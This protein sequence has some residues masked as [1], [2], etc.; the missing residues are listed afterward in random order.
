MG[1]ELSPRDKAIIRAAKM[2]HRIEI[3]ERDLELFRMLY[4]VLVITRK[5]ALPIYKTESYHDKRIRHLG[6]HGYL[7]LEGHYITL[8]LRGL[9]AL[10]EHK[11]VEPEAR[12]YQIKR[13]NYNIRAYVADLFL[14]MKNFEV[15]SPQIL[16]ILHNQNKETHFKCSITTRRSP[17]KE[18]F[19]YFLKDNVTNPY[20]TKIRGE[21]LNNAPSVCPRAVIFI[22]NPS[23]IKTDFTSIRNLLEVCVLPWPA[24]AQ[25]LDLYY[26]ANFQ[27]Q[28]RQIIGAA[29]PCTYTHA[30]YE[31]EECYY[32]DLILNNMVRRTT[33]INSGRYMAKPLKVICLDSQLPTFKQEMPHAHFIPIPLAHL[34]NK[35]YKED[36]YAGKL[37]EFE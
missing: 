24:G 28:I 9:E 11:M 12:L 7:N 8:G 14:D 15:E 23:L 20:M 5:H 17:Q 26:G 4:K 29:E 36:P 30:D 13:E 31:T 21:M 34:S 37:F 35:T 6:F 25:L 16:R 10:K 19:V 18:Y 2:P 3:Q 22:P 32:A 33:I 27:N 1:D